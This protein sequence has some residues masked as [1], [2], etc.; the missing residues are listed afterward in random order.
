MANAA[1]GGRFGATSEA[2][3]TAANAREA[4]RFFFST[5]GEVHAGY[6]SC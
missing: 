1:D 6:I 2:E 4:L 5:D 3:Q